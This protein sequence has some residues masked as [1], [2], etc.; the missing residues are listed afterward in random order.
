MGQTNHNNVHGKGPLGIAVQTG[1]PE[2]DPD[3]GKQHDQKADNG[4]DSG[5]F[6]APA[7]GK[8]AV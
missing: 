6:A 5:P 4:Q 1:Q 3:K 2:V 8:P 7:G